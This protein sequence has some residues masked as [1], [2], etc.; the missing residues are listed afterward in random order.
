M[1]DAFV[2][3]QFEA[4]DHHTG[5]HGDRLAGIDSP[6]EV[7]RIDRTEIDLAARD[8]L[9]WVGWPPFDIADV[10]EALRAQQLLGNV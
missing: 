3:E 2:P 10:G 9:G 8:R 1:L 5:Q 7:R 4:A 6:D